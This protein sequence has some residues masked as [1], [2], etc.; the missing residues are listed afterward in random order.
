M[1]A[2]IPIFTN[3]G[4]AAL[5]I[6]LAGASSIAAILFKPRELWRLCRCYPARFFAVVGC[7][8][9]L[10]AGVYRY[11]QRS[12]N[13]L[14]NGRAAHRNEQRYDW[15][16]IGL[17]LIAQR[18]LA[19]QAIPV[20]KTETVASVTPAVPIGSSVAPVL[21]DFS[22]CNTLGGAVP[23]NLRPLWSFAPESTMF[24]S[25]PRVVD[26]RIFAAGCEGELGG[27]TGLMACLD[28]DTGKP[29]WQAREIGDEPLK[30]FFST[31]AISADGR[32]VIIGQGLHNDRD[33]SLL[34]FDSATGKLLWQAP[35]PVH[36][37]SSPAIH[38]D[39]VVVGAGAIEG[40][41]GRADGDPGFVLAVDIR[42]GHPLWRYNVNDPESSPAI[43][44]DGTVYIGSGFNGRAI[45][46]LR[47]EPD[48][49]LREQGLD[50]LL[51]RLDVA[52]PVTGAATLAGDLVVF[53]AGNGDAVHSAVNA[54]GLVIAV[55]RTTGTLRW[56]QTVADSVLGP[57]A[58]RDGMLICGVRTGEV[59]ALS[60]ADGKILWRR[61]ISGTRPVLAGCAVTGPD[62]V[63]VSSDGHLAILR[64]EDGAVAEIRYL[65]DPSNPGSG[66]GLSSPLVANGRIFVGTET[67]GFR[68]LTGASAP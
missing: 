47:S 28:A 19:Q 43:D 23:R 33:C 24:L 55:E 39:M 62:I 45:V 9:L 10:A 67:G 37:E 66:L 1:F 16:K 58:Y 8:G 64:A 61:A 48:D 4:A 30:P 54:Q 41:D 68:C 31:P 50:R 59:V 20:A 2:V 49:R 11:E 65:N 63:A 51:W 27:F 35:T 46:A 57:I 22:H 5:P 40:K 14:K 3:V 42:D 53:G 36:I 18:N 17:S 52:Q 34:C 21:E 12:R 25:S 56:Q 29:I 32:C 15:E 6:I 44:T 13:R 26:K 60:A 38:G 7:L